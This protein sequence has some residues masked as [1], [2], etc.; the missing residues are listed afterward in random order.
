MIRFVRPLAA[1][2]LLASLF[3]V[4]TGAY[5]QDDPGGKTAA[6]VQKTEPIKVGD[7][8]K[9]FK[10]PDINNKEVKLSD[11]AGKRVVIFF[12]R[13][14][15][16]GAADAFPHLVK[17]ILEPHKKDGVVAIG[18]TTDDAATAKAFADKHAVP[19]PILVDKDQKVTKSFG[20]TKM[21]F[22]ALVNPKGKLVFLQ[23]GSD[24][25]PLA[26]KIEASLAKREAGD[27]GEKNKNPR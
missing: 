9:E 5:A 22:A 12:Y 4:G 15:T 2:T 21:P 24:L 7:M 17:E 10:L 6:P 23:G 3:L 25:K 8:V 16:A 26:S 19:F 14:D 27:E 18:I 13:K 11:F 1:A 20:E